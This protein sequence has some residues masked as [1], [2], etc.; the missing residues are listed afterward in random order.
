MDLNKISIRQAH[1]TGTGVCFVSW[2]FKRN[3][4]ACVLWSLW[5]FF[6][7]RNSERYMRG[8]GQT[9]PIRIGRKASTEEVSLVLKCLGMHSRP[10][11]LLK[12]I[13]FYFNM[14]SPNEVPSKKTPV[15]Y[16]RRLVLKGT[17]FPKRVRQVDF[18]MG[19]LK[20]VQKGFP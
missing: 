12:W 13:C 18:E 17:L 6:C 16:F 7:G 14:D 1:W 2:R 15:G 8:G 11:N 3:L 9:I 20:H 5:R 10:P 19:S 4:M